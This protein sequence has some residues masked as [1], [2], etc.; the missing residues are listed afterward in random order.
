ML[1][2]R[3]RFDVFWVSVMPGD[4]MEHSRNPIAIKLQMRG[5]LQ[6]SDRMASPTKN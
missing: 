4:V 5:Y 1:D 2:E 6:S 3:D